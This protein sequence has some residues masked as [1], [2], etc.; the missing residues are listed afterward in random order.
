MFTIEKNVPIPETTYAKNPNSMACM[1]QKTITSM[2]ELDSFTFT[3]K[4]G[5]A[6]A[7]AEAKKLGV[8]IRVKDLKNNMYRVWLISKTRE[9]KTV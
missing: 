3:A 5:G 8:T 6:I 1:L 4:S 9:S 7:Y 2:Q